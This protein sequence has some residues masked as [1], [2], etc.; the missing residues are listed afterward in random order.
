MTQGYISEAPFHP[1]LN[2]AMIP[3]ASNVDGC[4]ISIVCWKVINTRRNCSTFRKCQRWSCHFR[5][6]HIYSM[7]NDRQSTDDATSFETFGREEDFTDGNY[8]SIQ[9]TGNIIIW[10]FSRQLSPKYCVGTYTFQNVHNFQS[11]RFGEKKTVTVG[12]SV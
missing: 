8:F 11:N 4:D 3:I 7:V 6:F 9:S 2:V 5:S 10:C 12:T 1:P